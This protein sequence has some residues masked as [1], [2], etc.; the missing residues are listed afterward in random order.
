MGDR[1]RIQCRAAWALS[2]LCA[3]NDERMWEED[4]LKADKTKMRGMSNEQMGIVTE[5]LICVTTTTTKTT[6]FIKCS[7]AI[8]TTPLRM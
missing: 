7:A 4:E 2:G 3:P 1:W 8:F 6:M 5:I